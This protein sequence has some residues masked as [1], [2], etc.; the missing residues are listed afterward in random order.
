M[1]IVKRYKKFIVKRQ[2]LAIIGKFFIDKSETT[3]YNIK[4]VTV[5]KGIS[6]VTIFSPSRRSAV[7]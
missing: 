4:A 2:V 3:D 5:K 7:W 1:F 6:P